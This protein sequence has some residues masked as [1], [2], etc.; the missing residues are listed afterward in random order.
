MR[1]IQRRNWNNKIIINP[2]GKNKKKLSKDYNY[3]R[4]KTTANEAVSNKTDTSEKPV[5]NQTEH[6]NPNK[7]N[8]LI[9]PTPNL[10]IE[11]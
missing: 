8:V 2:R 5:G 4:K 11:Q 9:A 3:I 7:H 6:L 1:W 10:D